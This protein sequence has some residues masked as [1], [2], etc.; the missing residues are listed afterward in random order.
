MT[1]TAVARTEQIEGQR[2]LVVE[3]DHGLPRSLPDLLGQMAAFGFTYRADPVLRGARPACEAARTH[4]F[5]RFREGR[6]FATRPLIIRGAV[7]AA[8]IIPAGVLHLALT[9]CED[10]GAVCIRDV[11]PELWAGGR[12]AR[13]VNLRTGDER[14]APAA[15]ARDVVI[16]WYSGKRRAGRE[17]R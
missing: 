10:C 1:D 5:V 14:V 11:T 15:S 9:M 17:Y 12:P 16:G 3:N 6:W 4:R 8:R 2:V 13:L 7:N